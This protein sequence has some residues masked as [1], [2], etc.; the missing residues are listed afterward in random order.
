MG[1]S[2]ITH[3]LIEFECW[4]EAG[5]WDFPKTGL[6]GF[7]D[8]MP[9]ID[10]YT[11]IK[12]SCEEQYNIQR[13]KFIALAYPVQSVDEAMAIVARLRKEYFDATHVCWAYAIGLE[14]AESRHNDD[15]EPSGTAGRPIY[16]QIVSADLSNVLVA[17]VRY[18]GGVKLGTGGLIEAYKEGAKIVLESAEREEVLLH[19]SI[20]IQFN[21]SLTGEIMHRIKQ[22]EALVTGQDFI[23]GKSIIYCSLRKRNCQKLVDAINAVYG[24]EAKIEE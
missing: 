5:F 16:G 11:T 13:S 20:Y 6:F 14:R 18:F 10:S 15:G 12:K 9:S 4:I 17:V 22:H 19:D 23:D 1:S 21:P 7:I 3:P 8:L 2:P 24:A